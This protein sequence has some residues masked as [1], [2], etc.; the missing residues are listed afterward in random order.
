M[1][2][3]VQNLHLVGPVSLALVPVSIIGLTMVQLK[4]TRS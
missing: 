4:R 3:L 1:E 2:V